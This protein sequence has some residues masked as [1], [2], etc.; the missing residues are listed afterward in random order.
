MAAKLNLSTSPANLAFAMRQRSLCWL[1][2]AAL[3]LT[4]GSNGLNRASW[5][6]LG[7]CYRLQAGSH[8]GFAAS[9]PSWDL[10]MSNSCMQ[11]LG[12]WG[13]IRYIIPTSPCFW[14]SSF[15]TLSVSLSLS[16]SQNK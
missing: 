16:L 11:T 8:S 3:G 13:G 9:S 4:Q 2:V 15:L 7:W 1:I 12:G 14:I 10:N 6:N 5:A